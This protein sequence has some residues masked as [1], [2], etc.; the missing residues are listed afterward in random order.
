MLRPMS[1]AKI[2]GHIEQATERFVND[3]AEGAG[4][5]LDQARVAAQKQIDHHLPDGPATP[6]HHFF[7]IVDDDEPVGS[8]WFEEQMS[9]SP[10]RLYIFD[11]GVD[12]AH[13]GKGY[14][15]AA[16]RAIE[17]EARARGAEQVM[18]AVFHHNEGAV[19]LYE[20]LGY[21]VTESAEAGMRM[22]LAV[23]R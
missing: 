22:A 18:L 20:R 6:G 19:R 21:Q 8:L 5:P 12:P 4:L 23:E 16:L 13:R 2:P 9:E 15:T 3:V 7:E 10:P 14:G 17:D 11:V 1:P